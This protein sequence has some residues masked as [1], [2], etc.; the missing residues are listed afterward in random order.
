MTIATATDNLSRAAS[1]VWRSRNHEHMD[2]MLDGSG[3]LGGHIHRY[4]EKVRVELVEDCGYTATSYNTELRARLA[5]DYPRMSYR[6]YDLLT[7]L[8]VEDEEDVS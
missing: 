1:A 8:E 6:I 3:E 7:V 4:H 2:Y 5:P